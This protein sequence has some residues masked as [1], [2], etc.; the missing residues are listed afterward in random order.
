MT[1]E[2][3]EL[4]TEEEFRAAYPVMHELRTH[5]DEDAYM[6]L[7]SEMVPMGYRLYALEDDG[8][9]VALAGVG[10]GVNLYYAQYMWV[11]DLITTETARSRGYG[12]K[13]LSH[14]E[15]V[16]KAEGCV[17]IALSSALFRVDAHRFYTDRMGYDKP[18]FN[19]V[20][21]LSEASPR[22]PSP[23]PR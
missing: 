23:D 19:F 5:L 9:I 11:Y 17:T 13:L 6:A 15:E 14:V 12:E 8:R 3:R 2:V 4:T 16:A 22:S 20:K 7:L 21:A 18:G 10:A 1:T